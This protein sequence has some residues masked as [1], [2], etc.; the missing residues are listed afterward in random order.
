[1]ICGN[2]FKPEPV[3]YQGLDGSILSQDEWLPVTALTTFLT[4]V[5][6]GWYEATKSITQ[7]DERIEIRGDVNLILGDSVDFP[8]LSVCL[9]SYRAKCH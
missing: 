9:F 4:D 2:D 7:N 6:S 1:M 5:Y 8:T 3:Y